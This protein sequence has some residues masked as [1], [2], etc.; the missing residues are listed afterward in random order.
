MKK[1]IILSLII[2]FAISLGGIVLEMLALLSTT[3]LLIVMIASLLPLILIPIGIFTAKHAITRLKNTPLADGRAQLLKQRENAEA[4]AKILLK[5]LKRHRIASHIYTALLA[6]I[7]FSTAFF[8]GV[9]YHHVKFL[10]AISLIWATVL[11][12]AVGSRLVKAPSLQLNETACFLTKETSP[13]LVSL[14]EKAKT[15][16]GVK[17]A[18]TVLLYPDSNAS[19][20]KDHNRIFV[21]LG[22]HLLQ[23]LSENELY[24]ILLHEFSHVSKARRAHIA[25]AKHYEKIMTEPYNAPALGFLTYFF[26]LFDIPYLITFN[27]YRYANAIIEEREADRAMATYGKSEYAASAL[28]KL[29][30]ELKY[31]YENAYVDEKS[32]YAEEKAPNDL[33]RRYLN[34]FKA[35]EK[36]RCAFWNTLIECEILANNATHPTLKLRLEALGITEIKTVPSENDAAYQAELDAAL[37]RVEEEIYKHQCENYEKDR[38]EQ[39]LEPLARI[40]AWQEAGE[41]ITAETFGDLVSDFETLCRFGDAEALCDRAIE[42]LPEA[43]AY[44]AYYT[45]GLYMLHRYDEKGL[46]Y[47]YLAAENNHNYLD[48]ALTEIGTFCCFTGR[49][50][51]LAEYR[52]RS[53]ELAQKNKDE[54]SQADFISKRD[55]LTADPMP[56]EMREEILSFILSVDQNIIENIYLVRKTVSEDFFT[57]AF[58][59][60]FYGGTDAARHDIMHKIFRYLDTYPVDWQFSLFDYFECPDIR[61]DKIEGSLI[62]SKPKQS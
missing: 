36:E 19:I 55:T 59:I 1:P 28:I 39:Y 46:D 62:Y 54:N 35:A 17:E 44:Q 38:R 34:D 4:S 18:V 61:F 49:D 14:V 7:A 56:D 60:H 6:L 40:T 58:V 27:V 26:R 53:L 22:V 11:L 20:L 51:Q 30:Y 12:L 8:S 21:R 29:E 9:A 37:L 43:S 16:L 15:E 2:A 41:V 3:L 52:E 33:L 23:L 10:A 13:R 57:S 48:D 5:T 47:L 24:C 50:K 32:I 25:E 42:T 31:R 45:K